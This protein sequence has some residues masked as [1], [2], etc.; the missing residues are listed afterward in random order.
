MSKLG[1]PPPTLNIGGGIVIIMLESRG[2]MEL[3]L[4]G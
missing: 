2:P 3:V 4:S 1:A